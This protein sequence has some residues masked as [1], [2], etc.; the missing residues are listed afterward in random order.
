M[1]FSEG[2]GRGAGE[3]SPVGNVSLL[4]PAEQFF[5]E[6]L[7]GWSMQQTSRMLA[8]QTI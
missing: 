3:S 5:D 2:H 4:R 8:A 1:V 6:M 7:A